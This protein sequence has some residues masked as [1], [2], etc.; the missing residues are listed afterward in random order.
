M[1]EK[2]KQRREKKKSDQMKSKEDLMTKLADVEP[3]SDA[4]VELRSAIQERDNADNFREQKALME[5]RL[6]V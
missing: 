6:Y 2:M 4:E 1:K 5:V 3:G